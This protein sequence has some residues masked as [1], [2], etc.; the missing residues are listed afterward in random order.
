MTA[1]C[2]A[3]T[4]G[5]TA[6]S[7][8]GGRAVLLDGASLDVLATGAVVDDAVALALTPT[9]LVALGGGVV[10]VYELPGFDAVATALVAGAT[11]LAG[12]LG[13]RLLVTGAGAVTVLRLPTATVGDELAAA[14]AIDGVVPLDGER[15]LVMAG[16]DVA[17]VSVVSRRLLGRLQARLPAPPR[18]VGATAGRR[19][20]YVAQPGSADLLLL[21]LS[22][23]RTLSYRAATT[24]QAIYAHP[25]APWLAVATSRG[26][27][28][29]HAVT[30]AG[31]PMSADVER[32]ACVVTTPDAALVWFDRAGRPRRTSLEGDAVLGGGGLRLAMAGGIRT[33]TAASVVAPR[34]V[35]PT[36]GDGEAPT[37]L[38]ADPPTDEGT[39]DEGAAAGRVPPPR[40]ERDP[41]AAAP[42]DGAR[43]AG[44]A[45]TGGGLARVGRPRAKA[46]A[47]W[48]IDLADWVRIVL[49]DAAA[50]PPRPPLDDTPLAALAA[51]RALTPD[52]LAVVVLLYG[53]WLDGR[54]RLALDRV[55]RHA[56][57][58][59]VGGDGSLPR[60]QLTTLV[61]GRLALRPAVARFLDGGGPER[62][63]LHGTTPG[64]VLRRGRWWAAVSPDVPLEASARA[65][66]ARLGA[67]AITD[68]AR[69]GGA[70][71][72]RIALDEAWL[73]DRPLVAT[74]SGGFDVDALAAAPVRDDH[75]LI[76]VW[77]DREPPAALAGWK[78]LTD[79]AGA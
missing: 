74:P 60:A 78:P 16:A 70:R 63:V 6:V 8:Q 77:P 39:A 68:E 22:D 36:S 33:V 1:L 18:L 52:G 65:V 75:A 19:L 53:A 34:P 44:P 13:D 30:L 72:L 45:P 57:W 25:D 35:A 76:V 50:T 49:A 9:H 5:R 23:G 40:P 54:P 37:G 56:A 4:D 55:G 24:I 48:R 58:D 71:G 31:H 51:R 14:A 2:G 26:L 73:R 21:R 46:S 15:V 47:M 61:A 42:A 20:V 69:A 3:A 29:V 11:G 62:M 10:T 17:T 59:E 79:D 38:A 7:I 41:R 12:V 67:A 32:G 66:A 28:R 27:E 43:P 64:P